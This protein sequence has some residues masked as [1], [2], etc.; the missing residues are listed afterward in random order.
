ME[1]VISIFYL[2]NAIPF[3]HENMFSST[4]H[5]IQHNHRNQSLAEKQSLIHNLLPPPSPIINFLTFEVR[6]TLDFLP[7]LGSHFD[8][9][10]R[11]W[12]PTKTLQKNGRKDLFPKDKNSR[13]S[14]NSEKVKNFPTNAPTLRINSRLMLSPIKP[15]LSIMKNV[16][17]MGI[18]LSLNKN[19]P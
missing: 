18:C 3:F 2:I 10:D 4:L 5:Q 8:L 16:S 13:P 9:M 19:I 7:P 11:L 6:C 15:S 17:R 14:K 12:T 1:S